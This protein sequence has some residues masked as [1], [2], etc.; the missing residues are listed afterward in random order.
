MKGK[1]WREYEP[2]PRPKRRRRRRK[3]SGLRLIFAFALLFLLGAVG[4]QGYQLY[5]RI[6]KPYLIALD[7]GHGGSD[8]GALGI[9]DEVVLTENTTAFLHD[10]LE[11]DGRFRILLTRKTGEG[12][13]IAERNA[14]LV[15]KEPDLMLSIHGNADE[16]GEGYGFECYPSPP[17]RENY[18]ESYAFA[19]LLAEEMELA[20]SRLRGEDGVR[21]GY[22][23][24][25]A[26]GSEQKWLTESSDL[27]VYT[28]GTFGVL[29]NL[30]CPA[31]LVEQCFVTNQNDVDAFGTEAGCKQAAFA[32]YRA[33]CRQLLLEPLVENT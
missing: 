21:Y 5:E 18:G 13:T 26:D 17:G 31:V 3:K 32:Y 22:Y 28:Y 14:L 30:H 4:Y 11:E 9:V 7:A 2:A 10:I 20:G 24:P 29:E 15:K 25:Q 23:V 6:Q 27:T 16:T 33:I 12:A 8:S 1:N 19:L